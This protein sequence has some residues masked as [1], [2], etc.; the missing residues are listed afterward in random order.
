MPALERARASRVEDAPRVVTIASIAHKRGRI[1]FDDL[2]A[3]KKYVPMAAYAQSKLADVMFSF[4]L[5]R[6]LRAL[7]AGTIS[8]AAHP[9]VAN[10]RLFQSGEYPGFERAIRKVIGAGIGMFLGSDMDGAVPTLYAATAETAEGGGYYGPQGLLEMR[11]GDV[12]TAQVAPQALDVAAQRR[13]FDV[14]AEM[15]GVGLI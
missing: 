9:G 2:N 14:C 15:T 4:E 11:G 6:R 3:Q 5:E 10:T 8:L 7:G 1:D 12:G 13:L